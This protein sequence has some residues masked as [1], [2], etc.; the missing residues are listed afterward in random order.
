MRGRSRR[1]RDV[2]QP[3]H[4]HLEEQH[5]GQHARVEVDLKDA[6]RGGELLT[7][8]PDELTRTRPPRAS[9]CTPVTSPTSSRAWGMRGWTSRSSTCPTAR[10]SCATSTSPR[11]S[12]SRASSCCRARTGL[13]DATDLPPPIS[14][15]AALV[16]RDP[17]A[18]VLAEAHM[19]EV[20][21]LVTVGVGLL[22]FSFLGWTRFFGVL[23]LSGSST[24]WS[25]TSRR[26]GRRRAADGC[27][28]SPALDPAVDL[29]A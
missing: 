22:V 11:C 25:E 15:G 24:G 12:T 2:E 21:Q 19:S 14:R 6:Q 10:T 8:A 13:R 4:R 5:D 26:T 3:D 1:D 7:A 23:A 29:R 16:L 17:V 28:R 27:V 20:D 9:T 18:G